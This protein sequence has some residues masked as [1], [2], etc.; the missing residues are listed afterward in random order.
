V[1]TFSTHPAAIDISEGIRAAFS[2]LRTS[3]QRWL[4]IVVAGAVVTGV[5]YSLIGSSDT[6][7]LYYVNQYTNEIVWYPDAANRLWGIVAVGLASTA[8]SV[9]SSWIFAAAAI[10]GLRNR[11]MT[12]SFVVVRGLVTVVASIVIAIVAIGAVLALVVVIVAAPPLGLLLLFAAIPVS[13]YLWIRVI[14][15]TLAIFDGCGPIEGISEAWR[16]SRRAV[17]RLFGWGLMAFLISIGF[18]ICS[19]IVGAVFTSSKLMPVGQALSGLVTITGSCY[20]VFLMAVLYES[21]RARHDPAT[22][23]YAAGPGYPPPYPGGPYPYAPGPYPYAPGPYPAGPA[24]YTPT[25]YPGAPAWPGASGAYPGGQPMY[26]GAYPGAP[27]PYPGFPA[28]YPGGPAWPGAPA[29][30]PGGPAPDPGASGWPG[31]G[32]APGSSGDAGPGLPYQGAA[33]SYPGSPAQRW[34]THVAPQAPGPGSDP[35]PAWKSGDTDEPAPPV[36][37]PP[38]A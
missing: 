16:L 5:L 37:P 28:P 27:A 21:E 14:F 1:F 2:Y 9:V 26:P 31:Q 32:A 12:A 11:P 38:S 4:P 8:V 6:S 34:Q 33:P 18:A 23:G 22:Y 7:K 13:V 10:A 19:A 15:Y 25:P 36:D 3:W 20:T 17:L 30:Y 24:P 35:G 29:P